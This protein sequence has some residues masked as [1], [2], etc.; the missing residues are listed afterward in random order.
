M[1]QSS[2]TDHPACEIDERLV[3]VG[4]AF[5]A[6]T[7][8]PELMKPA[9]GPLHDPTSFAQAAAMLRIATG[10][11]RGD[12]AGPQ[13]HAMTV[14]IVRTIGVQQ[15]RASAWAPGFAFDRR[16]GVDEWNQLR[17]VMAVGP[18]APSESSD[19]PK[20]STEPENT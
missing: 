17:D 20:T 11:L 13:L 6:G 2:P 15:R 14:R 3:N 9:Q 7:Q 1:F 12:P 16:D 18:G 4:A 8:A 10:N 19:K 5:V